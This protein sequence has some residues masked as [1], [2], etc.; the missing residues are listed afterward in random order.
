MKRKNL[1]KTT[2]QKG[3]SAR[4]TLLAS[5]A[6][7]GLAVVVAG[8]SSYRTFSLP[9]WTTQ[10]QAADAQDAPA[11]FADLVAKVKPAVISVRVTIEQSANTTGMDPTEGNRTTQIP[12]GMEKFFQQFG[13]PGM[14]NGMRQGKQS[15][16]GEGSGF[17][18][19]P[20]GLSLIHI[21]EPTRQAEISYAVFC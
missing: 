8:P 5:A 21:S 13:M 2:N 10:A 1:P 20:E 9:S 19:L 18:I 11:G 6:G 3:L 15:I 4:L 12:P 16:T 17:F 7:L 14:P